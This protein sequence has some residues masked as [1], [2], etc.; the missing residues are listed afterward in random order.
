M[1][2]NVT[3]P[4]AA[5]TKFKTK[6]TGSNGHMPG[7]VIYD[8]AEG[9]ILGTKTDN[10]STATDTTSVSFMSV[11]KQISASAQ[12]IAT[13]VAG[14]LT[15]G[16]HAVTNTPLT[17]FG[18]GEYEDVIASTSSAQSLG[19]T[20][21]TGDYLSHLVIVPETTS[22]GSVIL[23]DGSSSPDVGFTI[24]VGGASSVSNLVPFTVAVGAKSASGAWKITTGASVH[25][26]AVGNFT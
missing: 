8:S 21:A 18:A 10:K 16:T 4:L 17:D 24:F 23:Y 25:V 13:S 14:T 7:H 11:W 22:P 2:D 19:A 5:S 20:G 26:R 3:T 1:A 12:A 15:V 6:D 9:E